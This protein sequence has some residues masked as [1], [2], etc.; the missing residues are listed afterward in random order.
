MSL[1]EQDRDDGQKKSPK[2]SIKEPYLAHDEQLRRYQ[3]K[4][5]Y[6]GNA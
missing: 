4:D 1:N 3:E 6:A 5:D 2:R